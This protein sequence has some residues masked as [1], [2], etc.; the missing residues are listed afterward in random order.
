MNS[1]LN[2][3]D[4]LQGGKNC[5]GQAALFVTQHPKPRGSQVI[6]QKHKVKQNRWV[7][8]VCSSLSLSPY[9][10]WWCSPRPLLQTSLDLASCWAYVCLVSRAGGTETK[11]L[12]RPVAGNPPFFIF[13]AFHW[14]WAHIHPVVFTSSEII[15]TFT[16]KK[17]KTQPPP[18]L[19]MAVGYELPLFSSFR[20]CCVKESLLLRFFLS[21]LCCSSV[22]SEQTK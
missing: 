6:G 9:L 5:D 11:Q 17:T 1:A 19:M 8:E 22:F 4:L 15:N 14:D 16:N 20:V 2:W 18:C 3:V 13:D 10:P 21:G 12:T 7:P